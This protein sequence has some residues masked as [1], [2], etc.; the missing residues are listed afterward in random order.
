MTLRT[1]FFGVMPIVIMS[2]LMAP[3]YRTQNQYVINTSHHKQEKV[4]FLYQLQF[5]FWP[6][7]KV[8]HGGCKKN[9][10]LLSEKNTFLQNFQ[11]FRAYS[12]GKTIW[13]PIH[14]PWDTLRHGRHGQIK[15]L[16]WYTK[17]I[18]SCLWLLVSY[19]LIFGPIP[20]CH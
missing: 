2:V 13:P 17:V 20:G 10:G 8:S 12:I 4:T 15:N 18:F 3:R 11:C 7:H 19:P 5:F 16:S 14:P 6:W 9:L 1:S